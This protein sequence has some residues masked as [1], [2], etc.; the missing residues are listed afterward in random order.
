[1]VGDATLSDEEGWQLVG[2]MK[3][4][5]TIP[6]DPN[7]EIPS[8]EVLFRDLASYY[9]TNKAFKKI[10]TKALHTQIINE[11]LKPVGVTR[12][13]LRSNRSR[14]RIGCTP[15]RQLKTP[16]GTSTKT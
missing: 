16:R 3:A 5:G 9:L 7:G 2:R 12:L 1:V 4:E 6:V 8:A 11:I 13:P 10:S 15:S 14:S